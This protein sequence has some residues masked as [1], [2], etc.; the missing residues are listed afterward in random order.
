MKSENEIRRLL[1]LNKRSVVN[2]KLC[3]S[4]NRCLDK[5]NILQWV[6]N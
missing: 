5:I 2:D 3:N 4:I 6:L 1:D